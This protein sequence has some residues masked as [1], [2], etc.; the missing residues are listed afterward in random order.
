MLGVDFDVPAGVVV[1]EALAH[2]E[3][4]DDL[5]CELLTELSDG[6]VVCVELGRGF[7]YG[8]AKKDV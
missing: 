1:D 6:R 4:C 5:L 2:C 3:C 8:V 7:G